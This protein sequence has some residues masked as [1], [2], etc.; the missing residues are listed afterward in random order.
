MN[1]STEERARK[2][3]QTLFESL[4]E[5][6]LKRLAT[7][8]EFDRQENRY[9]L[10]HQAIIA[11]MR[12]YLAAIRAP[13]VFTPQRI[14]C[15]PFEDMLSF[16]D[17]T[18]KQT[19]G[20]S[21]KSIPFMWQWLTGELLRDRFAVLGDAFVEAQQA[22]DDDAVRQAA[23]AIWAEAAAALAA[24][25]AAAEAD[26]DAWRE[27][28]AAHGGSR[29]LEDIRDMAA[30]LD[31]APYVESCKDGLPPRPVIGLGPDDVALIQ[32]Q[33]LAI[34][35]EKPGRELYL[36]LVVMG[37]LLQP[38]P[39][40]RVFRAL[41]SRRSDDV[42]YR[43]TDLAAAGNIV[44]AALE[45]D[46][47]N[48]A[49]AAADREV[50][51]EEIIK[52]ASRF[53]AAFKGITQDIGIRRD[54]EWGQRMYGARAAV[55]EAV[56]RH[57]L[58]NAERTVLSALPVRRGRIAP[59]LDHWPKED[60][61]FAADSRARS[62]A[63]ASRIAEHIGLQAACQATMGD[64]KKSLA[65]FGSQLLEALPKVDPSDADKAT[66]HLNTLV[67]L[68]ELISGSDEA[69]LLRRRGNAALNRTTVS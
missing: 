47:R 54:G 4:S 3:L 23:R 51:E 36:L 19:G 50:R 39:I 38:F 20:I 56:E 8:I 49:A 21:R 24:P 27:L 57:V 9:G 28:A 22:G 61:F 48:V 35:E 31:I 65:S 41:S 66:M 44:I 69:D 37:R 14:L 34:S 67:R 13:R 26:G 63:A 43:Q 60:D 53:A 16:D 32:Q 52:K 2:T 25:L 6:E 46:A 18:V 11:L 33:Y 55:S 62:L 58:R 68:T 40:L 17:P 10:P 45:D 7:R 42:L 29:R 12:P 30:V 59:L 15:V 1:E 64:L 5:T